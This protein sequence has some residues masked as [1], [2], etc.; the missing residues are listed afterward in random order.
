MSG[1]GSISRKSDE[2]LITLEFGFPFYTQYQAVMRKFTLA[3]KTARNYL[4]FSTLRRFFLI[5]PTTFGL[6]S[7]FY[8]LLFCD[9]YFLFI[10][11]S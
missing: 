2:C 11:S 6:I 10:T 8:F 7:F 9:S 1:K 4:I 3:G 5:L